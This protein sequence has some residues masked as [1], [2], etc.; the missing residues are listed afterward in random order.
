M[1]GTRY[2]GLDEGSKENRLNFSFLLTKNPILGCAH[3]VAT[4]VF[5]FYYTFRS[6]PTLSKSHKR[7]LP[8]RLKFHLRTISL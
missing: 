3:P 7:S 2:E 8:D 5:V 6:F 1:I 4:K